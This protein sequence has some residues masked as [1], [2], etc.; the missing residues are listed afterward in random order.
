[1]TELDKAKFYA[2]IAV[3]AEAFDTPVLSKAR[4]AL[5]FE[6]LAEFS[7]D[8]IADALRQH[9]RSCKWFPKV[10]EIIERIRPD[11]AAS[12]VLAWA[13]V[14]RLLRNSR[15]AQ[16]SNPITEQVVRDLGGWIALGMKSAA[17]LVWVE[18]EFV[19]R[20]EIHAEHGVDAAEKVPQLTG[21]RRGLQLIGGGA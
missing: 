15:A 10:S 2:L 16:S 19:G 13:E 20:Y 14:P 4:L 3:T 5:M 6:D 11:T 18:K 21:E 12:A 1:M 9:R 8:Q 7:L 17:E